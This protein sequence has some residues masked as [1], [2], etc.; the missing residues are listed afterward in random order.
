MFAI[1]WAELLVIAVVMV[2]VVKPEQMPEVARTLG[3]AYGKLQR[4]IFES[5]QI[6]EKEADAVR[7]PDP[8]EAEA[9][10][11]YEESFR[12]LEAEDR[13]AGTERPEEPAE[14]ETGFEEPEEGLKPRR[15]TE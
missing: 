5:R 1:G 8:A 4:L 9:R 13:L 15:R 2:V 3:R 12:R 6:L 10:A 7:R 14:F 11:A